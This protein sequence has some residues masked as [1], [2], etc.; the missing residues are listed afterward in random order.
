MKKFISVFFILLFLSFTITG[1]TISITSNVFREGVYNLIDYE[2]ILTDKIYEIQNVSTNKSAYIIV[3][4]N[5]LVILQSI[6][7]D[8]QSIKYDL[9]P[10]KSSYK[11]VIVGD[12]DVYI[13]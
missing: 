8:P 12:G 7:L 11:I 4:D 3:F 2:A 6:K 13:S 1:A 5:N 10:L 9:T